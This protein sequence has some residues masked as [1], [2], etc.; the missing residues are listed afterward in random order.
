MR[1]TRPQDA[2]E[3][4]TLDEQTA[5]LTAHVAAGNV[6]GVHKIVAQ[7]PGIVNRVGLDG[8]SPLCAAALWGH[9]DV[10][11]VLLEAAAAPGL[12]NSDGNRWTPLHAA[13]M[14]EQG[15]A[16]MLL[17]DFEA[18]PQDLDASNITP[19]DYASASEAIWPLFAARGC[20]RLTKAILLEKGV[21]RQANPALERELLQQDARDQYFLAHKLKPRTGVLTAEK[22]CQ[23]IDIL[24]KEEVPVL[25]DSQKSFHSLGI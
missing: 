5:I 10:L 23:P 9:S 6:S 17:L 13:A 12:R 7:S 14:Q 2:E 20:Q 25:Q 24:E 18:D 22:Q 21:I 1:A 8:T 19:C 4:V 11:R 15:K 3:S 16:C